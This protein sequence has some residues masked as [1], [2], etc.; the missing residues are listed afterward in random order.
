[1]GIFI[2]SNSVADTQDGN[3]L[4]PGSLEIGSKPSQIS[5]V[6]VEKSAITRPKNHHFLF[7]GI[8]LFHHTLALE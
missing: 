7:L 5:P 1:M 8:G 3:E 6:N 4:F 2:R